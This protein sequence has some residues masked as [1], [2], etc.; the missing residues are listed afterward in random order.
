MGEGGE[1]DITEALRQSLG[2]D[3]VTDVAAIIGDIGFDAAINSGALDGIPVV[4]FLTGV[5]RAGKEIQN[6]IFVRKIARFLHEWQRLST[7]E[8]DSFLADLAADEKLGDFGETVIVLL[9]RADHVK[10]P[11]LIARIFVAL[12][13][14]HFDYETAIRLAT[15]VDRCIWSDLKYLVEFKAGIKI[16]EEV[17]HSLFSAGLLTNGGIDGGGVDAIKGPSEIIYHVNRYGHILAELV[18]E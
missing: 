9:D 8:R 5:W 11:A 2:G 14:A 15:L 10:K 13:R 3:K 16:E 7:I 6:V 4:G 17:A 1:D 12:A 18:S